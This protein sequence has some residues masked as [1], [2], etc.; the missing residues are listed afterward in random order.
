MSR[1]DNASSDES[2]DYLRKAFLTI[3]LIENEKNY[4]F[5][6]ANNQGI[7]IAKGKYILLLNSDTIVL[8]D[9]LKKVKEF[10]DGREGAGIA[11]CKVLMVINKNMDAPMTA[12]IE[13]K[14][15]TPAV[16][17]N[18]WVL[19]GPSVDATNEQKHDNVKI[20]QYEFEIKSNPFKFTFEPH[21]LTAIE[22]ERKDEN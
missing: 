1:T 12:A 20:T 14:D 15:F 16:K 3:Q 22:I 4:G 6:R 17:G 11:G 10:M 13:F 8:G 2:V 5:A 9:C 19:N 21:S 18:A 7:K